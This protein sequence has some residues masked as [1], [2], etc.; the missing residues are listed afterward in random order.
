MTI[1]EER[2]EIHKAFRKYLR[3]ENGFS[4]NYLNT[5]LISAEK[6]LPVLIR[7]HIDP[8]FMD[9]YDKQYS[10]KDLLTFVARIKSHEEWLIENNGYTILKGLELYVAYEAQKQGVDISDIIIEDEEPAQQL[11]SE[12]ERKEIHCHGY[13]RDPRARKKCL[14]KWGRKCAACGFDFGAVY[15]PN[16][17]GFIE[18]HHLH[19]L[20]NVGKEHDTNAWE[21]LRPLCS[22]CHSVAHMRRPEPYSIDEIKE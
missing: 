7:E 16:A 2:K 6:H 21:D 20:A 8:S 4:S 3:I 19:P 10:L 12:G 15:G 9:L 5:L 1:D 11:Y 17:D 18:V 14:E 13:E 22:N